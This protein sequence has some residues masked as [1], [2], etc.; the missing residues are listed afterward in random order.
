MK[1]LLEDQYIIEFDPAAAPAI[2]LEPGEELEA[3][4][5]DWCFGLVSDDPATYERASRTPRCPAAGPV[6]VRGAAPGDAI[7]VRILALDPISPGHM[8]IRPGCSPFGDRVEQMEILRIP[9]EDG[10]ARL[11]TGLR[12]PLAPM[13]GVL[14]A[15]P[16]DAPA[17]TLISGDHGGNLDTREIAAGSTV[18]LPVQVEGGLIAFGDAHAVMGDGELSGSGVEVAVVARLAFDI[19]PGRNLRRPRI[20]SPTHMITLATRDDFRGA[21]ELATNDMA[22][23]IIELTGWSFRDAALLIGAAGRLLVSHVINRPGP[24]IKLAL[25]RELLQI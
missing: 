15:T 24:T 10:M 3:R 1:T 7:A 16:A 17:P 9:L 2:E 14:G 22:D 18:L 12:V 25:S 8:V 23:W 21:V 20:L 13:L 5:K 11:P 4:V 6:F 19:L